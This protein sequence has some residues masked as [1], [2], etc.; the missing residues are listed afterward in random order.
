M[1]IE[2]L[3]GRRCIG[4]EMTDGGAFIVALDGVKLLVECAWR[5]VAEGRLKVAGRDHGE[6]FG[7]EHPVDAG[8]E[9]RTVLEG[10]R[11]AGGRIDEG[12]G[13][14]LLEFDGGYRLEVWNDCTGYEAWTL[15]GPDG[16]LRVAASGGTV[17]AFAPAV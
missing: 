15:A 2:F 10:R 1:D 17:S 4:I 7:L 13:D 5:L 14:L 16:W 12:L 8:A 9:A 11:V 6:R 3:R